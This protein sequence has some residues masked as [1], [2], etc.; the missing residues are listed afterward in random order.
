MATRIYT[1]VSGTVGVTPSTWNFAAQINPVTVPGTLIKNDGSVMTSKAEATGTT[2][3][4]ARAMGRTIIGPLAAQSI[5]GATITGQMRGSEDN[6]GANATLALAVKL[7]QPDGTDR[8]VLLAQTASDAATAGNELTT[9]V[10][11]AIFKDAAETV[12]ISLTPQSAVAGDYLVIEWGFR[13]ATTTSRTITLSYGNDSATD[14]TPNDTTVT[15]ANNPWWE[16]SQTL[17]FPPLT[18]SVTDALTVG[19][20]GTV[21]VPVLAP[22]LVE[23]LTTS[24]T[25]TLRLPFLPLAVT[26]SLTL[27]DVP[28]FRLSL[29][30]SVS[31]AVT[32]GES[33]PVLL[34]VMLPFVT[35]PVV[36]TD[37]NTLRVPTSL[38]SVSESLTVGETPAIL[39]PLMRLVTDALTVGDLPTL[40]F[41][42]LLLAVSE[43][44]GVTDTISL[45]THVETPAL[46][47][48]FAFWLGGGA[49]QSALITIPI[50]VDGVT[51]GDTLQVRL[52]STV[53]PS[54]PLLLGE[55]PT[56]RL[57]VLLL[58]ATEAVTLGEQTPVRL[59]VLLTVVTDTLT[60]GEICTV[61]TVLHVTVTETV[62]L[63]ES[64]SVVPE[65]FNYGQVFT[66]NLTT[67]SVP[68]ATHRC[69]TT[70]LL[71]QVYDD[72]SPAQQVTPGALTVDAA[73]GDVLV[74]FDQ[75]QNGRL[76]INGAR[77]T[78]SVRGNVAIPFSNTAGPTITIA[79]SVHALATANLLIQVYD[80]GSPAAQ[81]TPGAVTVAS[82]FD[83]Q[84]FLDD[85]KDGVVVINGAAQRSVAPN[86]VVPFSTTATIN[87][88][89]ATHGLSTRNLFIQVYDNGTPAAQ[90][91]PG[92]VTVASNFDVQILLHDAATGLV[93]LNGST[94]GLPLILISES[95]TLGDTCALQMSRLLLGFT[96][97][98]TV[99][100]TP[101]VVMPRLPFTVTDALTVAETGTVVVPLVSLTVTDVITLGDLPTVL[102]PLLLPSV[103]ENVSVG[104]SSAQ[105]IPVLLLTPQEALL[106]DDSVTVI[107]S[108][109]GILTC[110]VTETVTLSDPVTALEPVLLSAGLET[111]TVGE[112]ALVFLPVLTSA[113]SEPVSVGETPALLV[114]LLPLLVT[115]AIT[116]GDQPTVIR[117]VVG[118]LQ[119]T[120]TDALTLTDPVSLRVPLL[121]L[122]I[123]D[124]FTV[125]DTVFVL[126]PVLAPQVVEPLTGGDA[127]TLRL[128]VLLLPVLDSL[129]VADEVTVIRTVVGILQQ[130]VTDALTLTESPTLRVPMVPLL[131]S[132][133][134]TV[135]ESLG[136]TGL[137]LPLTVTDVV[138]VGDPIT[139]LIPFLAPSLTDAITL[140]DMPTLCLPLLLTSM[141]DSVVLTEPVTLRIPLLP[142][143]VTEPLLL[144]E[145]VTVVRSIAGSWQAVVSESMTVD[146]SVSVLVP[147]L[148]PV[149]LDAL[150]LTEASGVESRIRLTIQDDLLLGESGALASVLR[151]S[152]MD[153]VAVGELV[154]VSGLLLP[155]AVTEPLTVS[156]SIAVCCPVL[157]L[158][159]LETL[160]VNDLPNVIRT[161]VG[162]Y[163]LQVSDEVAPSD[164]GIIR[165]P[166]LILLTQDGVSSV[167]TPVVLLP[168]LPCLVSETVTTAESLGLNMLL[169]P[170][171][172]EGVSIAD[173]FLAIQ[174]LAQP[175]VSEVLTVGEASAFTGI[176]YAGTIDALVVGA[177]T[178]VSVGIVA[179][180]IRGRRQSLTHGHA[181]KERL[182]GI[183]EEVGV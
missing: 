45:G 169:F 72:S 120:V 140:N 141:S 168:Q 133:P 79:A 23:P 70:N 159:A 171:V 64:S 142:L 139:S 32:L 180:I 136:I 65:A 163:Q 90:L 92:S 75:A 154:N 3:P 118:V 107:R 35:E 149:A 110:A 7:V 114:P 42:V 146:E 132:E 84:I 137:L 1:K 161:V 131:V 85:P 30:L 10:T 88:P 182:L 26:E 61:G 9:T 125:G 78:A 151:P 181:Q 50:V 166:L 77:A 47:S 38:L 74:T 18:L 55:T 176:L 73:N 113:V 126:A 82:N 172:S 86:V 144:T 12:A 68:G 117:A 53:S 27:G 41:P 95:L 67:W 80:N 19:D 5:A 147:F 59:P 25:P 122:A 29:L 58:S 102:I 15:A 43:S 103:T 156:D 121:P 157:L 69:G 24:D 63:S 105:R 145:P 111:L 54:D 160:A 96:D 115:D 116:V 56:V 150:T 8:A 22:Q 4:T 81:L 93:V 152:V 97:A 49:A 104:E 57:P 6:I 170:R 33:T 87:I 106:L 178:A 175:Q 37:S 155:V 34:P 148:A 98:L 48:F 14:L 129:T 66:T 91:T 94:Q 112:T 11:N 40:R 89:A 28:A 162:I 71:I 46:H 101:T 17:L 174:A 108:A 135:G 39:F 99:G 119:Q 31:D 100:E 134:L 60:V 138:T 2:S 123:T 44:L 165:V 158:A 153:G 20:V 127:V 183:E 52:L 164:A 124:A 76:V 36:V 62:S 21:Q 177:T 173:D 179:N 13:S 16:F 109:V 167:D 130:T 51:V 128:P 143:A 83:V